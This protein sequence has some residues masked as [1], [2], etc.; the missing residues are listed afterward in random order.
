MLSFESMSSLARH[1]H[2]DLPSIACQRGKRVLD[3]EHPRR[4]TTLLDPLALD[5]RNTMV[6][7]EQIELML[8]I[9]DVENR[10]RE[11]SWWHRSNILK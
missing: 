7:D 3:T 2:F 9:L 11:E 1:C 8:S 6:G 5:V 4:L 10:Y